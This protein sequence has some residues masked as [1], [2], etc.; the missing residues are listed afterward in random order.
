MDRR[1]FTRSGGAVLTNLCLGPVGVEVEPES[2]EETWHVAGG[3]FSA[4]NGR[5]VYLDGQ[6]AQVSTW[7]RPLSDAEVAAIY[8]GLVK[9]HRGE[10][11][12]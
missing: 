2:V 4:R 9:L 1:T 7:A 6:V 3:A 8:G 11:P 5:V 10:Y 12:S